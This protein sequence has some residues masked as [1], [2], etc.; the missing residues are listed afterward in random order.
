MTM[1]T[2]TEAASLLISSSFWPVMNANPQ[3][4]GSPSIPV[5]QT[6]KSLAIML[7]GELVVTDGVVAYI[8][9]KSKKRYVVNLAV[10]WLDLSATRIHLA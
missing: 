9:N 1:L 2:I 7:V 5:S 4:P 8:S 6:L 10:G 3:E